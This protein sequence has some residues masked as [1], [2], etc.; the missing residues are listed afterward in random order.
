MPSF[1]HEDEERLLA[2]MEVTRDLNNRYRSASSFG[3]PTDELSTAL[4][5]AL[6]KLGE[7][8]SGEPRLFVMDGHSIGGAPVRASAKHVRRLLWRELRLKYR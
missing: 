2:F 5:S 4:Q 8:I 1:S 3:S 7:H 6:D